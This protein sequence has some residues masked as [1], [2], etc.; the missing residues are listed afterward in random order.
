MRHLQ[1]Q[2]ELTPVAGVM[3]PVGDDCFAAAVAKNDGIAS[4]CANSTML[5]CK[6]WLRHLSALPDVDYAESVFIAVRLFRRDR[7]RR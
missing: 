3:S 7:C 6:A 2:S 4:A 5:S 1:A